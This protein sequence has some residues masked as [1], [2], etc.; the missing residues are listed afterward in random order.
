MKKLPRYVFFIHSF[1][2]HSEIFVY[3]LCVILKSNRDMKAVN[4]YIFRAVCA[5][6]VGILLVAN[7]ERV[8]NLL[9]QVIGGLFLISG[10]VTVINYSVIR[11]S[12]K[13]TVKPI[14]P[15]IG[16]GSFLFGVILGFY[17]SS[18]ITSLMFIV[19]G[20][21][22]IAGINQ[23]WNMFRLRHFIPFRWYMLVVA[24]LII[25]LGVVVIANPME[26]ASLPFVLIG[27]TC[28]LYGV[29]E[30]VNGVRWR[31]YDRMNRQKPQEQIEIVEPET[32]E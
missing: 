25:A 28:M 26:S 16:L 12:D 13:E 11:F 4:S 19:G 22:V 17:P 3:S 23:L 31:K 1:T 21:M 6:L 8:T 32:V 14:F 10:L 29:S 15:I 27:F 2:L 9:V 20:L 30:L 18:F 24:L 7:P 5:L